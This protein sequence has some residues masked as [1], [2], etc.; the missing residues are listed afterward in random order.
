MKNYLD[1]FGGQTFV[2]TVGCGF[3][4]STMRW[5]DH[6]DNGSYT[7]II[8]ASVCAYIAK[9]TVE[10]HGEIRADVQKTIAAAQVEASPSSTVSQVGG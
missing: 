10:R 8:L 1:L 2:L 5:F 6:I 9:T 7:A 3:V 4:T